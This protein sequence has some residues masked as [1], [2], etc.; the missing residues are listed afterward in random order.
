MKHLTH[1]K[2][3]RYGVIFAMCL[4]SVG[5][6]FS[7]NVIYECSVLSAKDAIVREW[8]E[9]RY[10]V[11]RDDGS[12][13]LQFTVI[14][15]AFMIA[16]DV[17]AL[18]LYPGI[19]INDFEILKDR[20]Y[21]CGRYGRGPIFGWFDAN[22]AING[23]A[24]YNLITS[25]N[26][27]DQIKFAPAQLYDLLKIEVAYCGGVLHA[28][29][30]GEANTLGGPNRCIVDMYDD[31]TPP[32]WQCQIHESYYK[33]YYYDDVAV[34]DNFV[35]VV[36]HKHEGNNHY[37]LAFP[38]PPAPGM[39]IFSPYSSPWSQQIVASWTADDYYPF[40]TSPFMIEHLNKDTFAIVGYI[41]HQD[42]TCGTAIT[43]YDGIY[44]NLGC[45]YIPQGVAD[46]N[47]WRLKDFR[48]NTASRHLFLLEDMSSPVSPGAMNSVLLRTPIPGTTWNGAFTAFYESGIPYFSMDIH[49]S[50]EDAVLVGLGGPLRLWHHTGPKGCVQ[51]TKP[52]RVSLNSSD[53][54]GDDNY[55]YCTLQELQAVVQ[56][57][58]WTQKYA[59]DE[60]CR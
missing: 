36:G 16:H 51:Y 20:V 18:S 54:A 25:I 11:Y 35:T 14:D 21:F 47:L 52:H 39:S 17:A 24:N 50:P 33:K 9:G 43:L 48:Y 41:D 49:A 6:L 60:V 31:M 12:S 46:T 28:F 40:P 38:R 1:L 23:V 34:T 57:G 44:N 5:P 2:Q 26:C 19:H 3:V 37:L 58:A 13:R 29:M 56:D 53:G 59:L 55:F 8:T 45:R 42:G 10:V 7:Q 15:T 27:M 30:I 22:D 4:M 32:L